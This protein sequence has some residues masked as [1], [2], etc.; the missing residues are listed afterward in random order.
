M[1]TKCKRI[2][3][4]AIKIENQGEKAIEHSVFKLKILRI[5]TIIKIKTKNI[6]LNKTYCTSFSRFFVVLGVF[7]YH[8]IKNII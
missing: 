3:S 7:Y 1:Y 5:Q 4:Y 2:N 8:F 6:P